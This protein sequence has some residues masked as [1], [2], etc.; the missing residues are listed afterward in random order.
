MMVFKDTDELIP[1]L[2]QVHSSAIENA[3]IAIEGMGVTWEFD[4]PLT[5]EQ[6]LCRVTGPSR[7][8]ARLMKQSPYWLVQGAPDSQ[9]I[10]LSGSA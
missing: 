3:K 1:V 6:Y 8:F 9:P 2:L 4:F 10:P 5:S 7:V